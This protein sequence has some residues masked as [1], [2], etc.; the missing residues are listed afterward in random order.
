MN[1]LQAIAAAPPAAARLGSNDWLMFSLGPCGP[2]RLGASQQREEALHTQVAELTEQLERTK[3]AEARRAASATSHVGTVLALAEALACLR[4]TAGTVK[5]ACGSPH[6]APATAEL[7]A[8]LAAAARRPVPPVPAA[9]RSVA[10]AAT[11][12]RV[13]DAAWEDAV[14]AARGPDTAVAIVAWEAE[15]A[16]AATEIARALRPAVASALESTLEGVEAVRQRAQEAEKRAA[17]ALHDLRTSRGRCVR[18]E[19]V[20]ELAASQLHSVQRSEA[21]RVAQLES[22]VAKLRDRDARLVAALRQAADA[23]DAAAAEADLQRRRANTAETEMQAAMVALLR[24]QNARSE[25]ALEAA[26]HSGADSTAELVAELRAAQKAL[27]A[28]P[29]VKRGHAVEGDSPS[30][31]GRPQAEIASLRREVAHQNEEL[32]LLRRRLQDLQTVDVYSG[33][34]SKLLASACRD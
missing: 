5:G 26:K 14:A 2:Q 32:R 8:P 22:A 12:S 1:K 4:E 30:S 15:A 31:E 25:E 19:E 10:D 20:A 7:L 13:T 21:T 11:T 27:T 16:S 23:Q 24:A 28:L 9:L 17:G 6:V 18:A 3:A 29:S 34:M 33:T